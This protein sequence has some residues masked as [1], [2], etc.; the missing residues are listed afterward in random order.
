MTNGNWNGNGW[1]LS[2]KKT[3]RL[4]IGLTI[5]VWATQTL[6]QQWGFGQDVGSSTHGEPQEKFVPGTAR[7]AAGASLELRSEATVIG[8]E[9]TLKQVC[10]WSDADHSVFAPIADL[11]LMRL[12][13]RVP[14][15]SIQMIDIRSTLRDAG[16]NVAAINFVGATS[17]TVGRS[18]V[19]F[20]EADALQKWIDAHEG[21]V[22]PTTEPV[23]EPAPRVTAEAPRPKPLRELL[24]EDL[25]TRLDLPREQM[26]VTF[27]P[28]DDR[29]LELCEPHF[30]FQIEPKR[31]RD[32]GEVSWTVKVVADAPRGDASSRSTDTTTATVS[33]TARAWQTQLVT[34]RPLTA[35]Q[36]IGDQDVI[37]RRALVERLGD[38]RPA[39]RDAAI[40]QQAARDIKP[41]T[42]LTA[43]MVQAVELV[44]AGQFVTV[45]L[46]RGG[47][48][49]KTVARALEAGCLGQ[50]IRVKNE[51]TRE[52]SNVVLTGPQTAS[53]SGAVGPIASTR[54]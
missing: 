43:R 7:F 11:T 25:A 28:Q 33:G 48:E 37:E 26:Q 5:V 47:V 20:N 42:V 1:P 38:D 6:M 23:A 8:A 17:C 27:R 51:T 44:R 29:V 34:S 45:V 21:K 54:D 18:D 14:F 15:R 22:G 39:T 13:P 24:I 16:V 50:T 2:K 35:R 40:G 9:V 36:I 30:R 53:M 49:V 32:L 31:A 10:R 12:G 41:G 4:L 46:Q 19:E 3:V 52:I